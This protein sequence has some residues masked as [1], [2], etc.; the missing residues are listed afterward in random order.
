MGLHGLAVQPQLDFLQVQG[1][2]KASGQTRPDGHVGDG[3]DGDGGRAG[4]GAFLSS[5]GGAETDTGHRSS[6]T[7]YSATGEGKIG[8]C[9][10]AGLQGGTPYGQ[11]GERTLSAG[12]PMQVEAA[13]LVISRHAAAVKPNN[14]FFPLY[15]M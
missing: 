13:W 10:R 5:F 2:V 3:M 12:R 1:G 4:R 7:N 11:D 15:A 9:M 14:F 8:S 6:I